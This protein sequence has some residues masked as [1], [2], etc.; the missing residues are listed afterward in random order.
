M[1]AYNFEISFAMIQIP[2]YVNTV[3]ESR[4]P[5]SAN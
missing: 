4:Q 1:D 2:F 5:C 3:L